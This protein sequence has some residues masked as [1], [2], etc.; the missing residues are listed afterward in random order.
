MD[1]LRVNDFRALNAFVRVVE[2]GSVSA[3]ARDRGLSQPAMSRLIGGLERALG[4]RLLE[5]GYDGMRV[6]PEGRVFYAGSRGLI[7]EL[8][9]LTR[10]LKRQTEQA[11]GR[12]RVTASVA[13][14]V[15]HGR[16][17]V[18]EFLERHP[19]IEIDLDAN[20]RRVDLV[21]GEFDVALRFGSSMPGD[22]I[23]RKLGVSPRMLVASPALLGRKGV[24]R[25]P[26]DLSE[27]PFV[28]W[29]TDFEASTIR[30]SGPDGNAEMQM[31]PRLRLSCGI[32]VREA[33]C[34]GVG[35]GQLPLWI[36][37][38]SLSEGRLVSLLPG[39]QCQP[40]DV[41][42][43]YP[44]RKYLPQRVKLFL[45]FLSECIQQA[46]GFQAAARHK[47]GSPLDA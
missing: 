28:G 46:Q 40:Q 10:T 36:V 14:C 5:R 47:D 19:G 13:M 43:V 30:L 17:W 24:P 6:T 26:A 20:D 39:W 18:Q 27:L 25:L 8:G 32:L 9:Q 44:S 21:D 31:A 7:E 35:I 45:D 11:E 29:T 38:D 12:L 41:Y 16:R 37:A 2:L 22:Q 4:T 42:A 34:D 23:A 15:L 1:P 3:A 33:V